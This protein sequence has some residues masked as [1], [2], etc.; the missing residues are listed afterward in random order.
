MRRERPAYVE[1]TPLAAW[2]YA[3]LWGLL[4]L[5]A[6]SVLAGWDTD[7][8]A[9]GRWL[10]AASILA[11]GALVHLL[12]V[13]LTVRVFD[14]R[15]VVSIGWLGIIRTTVPLDDVE[16]VEPVTYRPIR[17]FGGW[18]VR[19]W[20]K[21]RAWTARG[22]QAVIL[23]LTGDRRLYVGS[24]RPLRLA[25]RIRRAMEARVRKGQ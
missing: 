6:Y 16:A 21:K 7:L 13:G 1:R 12:L 8:P 2:V 14:D 11:S 18:G 20:G 23:W 15:I 24:D 25:E 9:P 3:L 22:D 5:G 17:E 4:I 10:V 19:G